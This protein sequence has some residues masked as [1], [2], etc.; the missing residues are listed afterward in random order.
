MVT[1]VKPRELNVREF[2]SKWQIY[3]KLLY[4]SISSQV[5]ITLNNN[6]KFLADLYD[7]YKLFLNH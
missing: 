7:L 2:L 6:L 5:I 1:Q 3:P 4:H